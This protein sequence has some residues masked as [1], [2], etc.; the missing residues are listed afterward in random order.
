MRRR[1]RHERVWEL[2]VL[3]PQYRSTGPRAMVLGM[4]LVRRYRTDDAAVSGWARS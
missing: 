3:L 2:P 4:T 1:P